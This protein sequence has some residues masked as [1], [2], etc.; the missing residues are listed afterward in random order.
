[1]IRGG[2]PF[3]PLITHKDHR[4]GIRMDMDPSPD[5]TK[6]YGVS[7][8]ISAQIFD[9]D[10]SMMDRSK[11]VIDNLLE[12]TN[13]REKLHKK[14]IRMEKKGEKGFH[15]NNSIQNLAQDGPTENNKDGFFEAEEIMT[16]QNRANAV[17]KSQEKWERYLLKHQAKLW[18]MLKNQARVFTVTPPMSEKQI[19]K[20]E[21]V[22]GQAEQAERQSTETGLPFGTLKK[23]GFVRKGRRRRPAKGKY[24]IFEAATEGRGSPRKSVYVIESPRD[25]R[26]TSLMVPGQ[27]IAGDPGRS[28]TEE[29]QRHMGGTVVLKPSKFASNAPGGGSP[30]LFGRPKAES[31]ELDYEIFDVKRGA[32]QVSNFSE[33]DVEKMTTFDKKMLAPVE[34]TY[35]MRYRDD[36]TLNSHSPTKRRPYRAD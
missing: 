2:N 17:K 14:K 21:H 22:M 33:G 29:S 8:E 13:Q 32:T 7:N 16:D 31:P 3:K 1:M 11:L 20:M 5:Y 26:R 23:S 28:C 15:F 25:S 18:T 24:A 36:V 35:P 10:M 34:I 19:K 6:K 4:K 30:R 27:G 12:K 9:A